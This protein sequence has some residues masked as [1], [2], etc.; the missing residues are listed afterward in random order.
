MTQPGP[1]FTFPALMVVLFVLSVM[2]ASLVWL[3]AKGFFA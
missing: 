3:L 2:A 1:P